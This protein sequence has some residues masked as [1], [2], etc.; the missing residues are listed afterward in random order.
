MARPQFGIAQS[1]EAQHRPLGLETHG[2][3]RGVSSRPGTFHAAGCVSFRPGAFDA[4]GDRIPVPRRAACPRPGKNA[5]PTRRMSPSRSTVQ[6]SCQSSADQCRPVPSQH[7]ASAEQC[8]TSTRSAPGQVL[9]QRPAQ[10][11]PSVH[12]ALR[13]VLAVSGCARRVC[14]PAVAASGARA[15]GGSARWCG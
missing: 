13:P 2:D 7:R 9:T 8:Q 6:A 5:P 3:S 10:H 12:P 4:V 1:G 11:R 14:P 15:G